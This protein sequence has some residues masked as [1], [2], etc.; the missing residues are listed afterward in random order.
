MVHIAV[1]AIP[2]GSVLST[3][4]TSALNSSA[5]NCTGQ[6][7][8]DV[9]TATERTPEREQSNYRAENYGTGRGRALQ[10][11]HSNNKSMWKQRHPVLEGDGHSP[12]PPLEEV[13]RFVHSA[14]ICLFVCLFVWWKEVA[15]GILNVGQKL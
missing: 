7:G 2:I 10:T 1:Q 12:S 15:E 13:D 5:H 6:W 11:R 3:F 14:T 4:L 9:R 8:A